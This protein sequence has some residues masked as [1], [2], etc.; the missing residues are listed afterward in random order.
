MILMGF[1]LSAI[2]GFVDGCKAYY[3]NDEGCQLRPGKT[4]GQLQQ[5]AIVQQRMAASQRFVWQN[6]DLF[7]VPVGLKILVHGD[8]GSLVTR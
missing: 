8:E 1:S 3:I 4:R 6:S 2:H 7:T 5:A